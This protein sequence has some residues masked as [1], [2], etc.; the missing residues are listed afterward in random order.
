MGFNF[1]LTNEIRKASLVIGLKKHLKQ[2]F[3][4]KSLARQRQIPIYT[5]NQ[6]SVYQISKLIEYIN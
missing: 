6:V 2:N 4:L 1:L 5:L 3:K